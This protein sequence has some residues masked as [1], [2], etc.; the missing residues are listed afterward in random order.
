MALHCKFQLS[1]TDIIGVFMQLSLKM[2]ENRADS[3]KD[4][5]VYQ[6]FDNRLVIV[7]IAVGRRDH[8]LVYH[9]AHE[10]T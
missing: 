8:D 10:R 6:V 9:L 2:R 4:G 3:A 7:V 5:L 1:I